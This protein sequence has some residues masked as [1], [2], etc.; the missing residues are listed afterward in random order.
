MVCT[1]P[2]SI[3]GTSNY[4]TPATYNTSSPYPWLSLTSPTSMLNITNTE[5]YV[6]GI[7]DPKSQ[8]KVL[9]TMEGFA[10]TSSTTQSSFTLQT[11]VSQ[12]ARVF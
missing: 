2:S 7:G 3:S 9:I 5:F 4:C 11:T 10:G 1:F 12:R 8:P 6:L